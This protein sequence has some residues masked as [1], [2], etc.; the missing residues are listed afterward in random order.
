VSHLYRQ[1]SHALERPKGMG[2]WLTFSGHSRFLIM[3]PLRTPLVSWFAS[4]MMA[5]VQSAGLCNV[6]SYQQHRDA[7]GDVA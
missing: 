3:S 5:P 7:S 6:G 1:L 2:E 4:R